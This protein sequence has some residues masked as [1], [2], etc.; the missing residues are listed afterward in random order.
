MQI[1]IYWGEKALGEKFSGKSKKTLKIAVV[2][3]LI[4]ISALIAVAVLIP[5]HLSHIRFISYFRK[6]DFTKYTVLKD[7]NNL[8]KYEGRVLEGVKAG[9]AYITCTGKE[10]QKAFDDYV[11]NKMSYEVT[12]ASLAKYQGSFGVP[13]PSFY[14]YMFD[15][16]NRSDAEE[17]YDYYSGFV[18]SSRSEY[19]E[20]N[21]YSYSICKY[22]CNNGCYL[23]RNT[24]LLF[25]AYAQGTKF[26]EFCEYMKIISPSEQKGK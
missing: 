4:I 2:S 16:K 13:N 9:H 14:F 21:G 25:E 7:Y 19:G 23:E 15:F 12:R 22:Q 18:M 5:N 20:E 26:D 17:F 3:S 1:T 8:S 10:A 6:N 11:R 24:V